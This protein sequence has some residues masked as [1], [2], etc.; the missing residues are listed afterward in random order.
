MKVLLCQD[1]E[2][3][4]WLGDVVEVKNGYARNY[5]LPYGVAT[6][7]TQGNIRSLADAKAKKTVERK[8]ALVQLERVAEA[9][10]GAEAVIASKANEQGHLFGS[11]T[12]RDIA[13]N[14]RE[15]GFE[16][17]DNMIKLSHG[18]HIK[19]VGTQEVTIKLAAELT[20]T[21]SVVVVPLVEGIESDDS[22]DDSGD[23]NSD[24]DSD[25]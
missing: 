3:L 25:E 14:L 15:Q 22:G 18:H 5:L 6:V 24:S 8:L 21:V 12:E 2:K 11:V 20:A 23:E 9:V 10:E 13:V 16:V 4:G 19:E 7:P 1:V 17:A